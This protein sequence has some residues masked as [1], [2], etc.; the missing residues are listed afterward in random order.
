[1]QAQAQVPRPPLAAAAAADAAAA[2]VAATLVAACSAVND[3]LS[4]PT[5]EGELTLSGCAA[6][7]AAHV[8]SVRSTPTALK[9]DAGVCDPASTAVLCRWT[10]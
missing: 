4:T 5:A 8:P 3:A 10:E 6:A 1:M 9:V 7:T 2:V